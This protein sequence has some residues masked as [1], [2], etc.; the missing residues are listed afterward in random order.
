ML[1]KISLGLAILIGLATLFVAHV[2]VAPQINTLNENLTA[3]KKETT[4][5]RDDATKSKKEAKDTKTL[6]EA[7]NKQLG[8]ATNALASAVI[9]A[10]EQKARADKAVGL[11]TGVTEERNTAQQ[12][13]NQWKAL[14]LSIEQ[15]RS[16]RDDL[17]K[18]VQERDA[19][20][21]EKKVLVK[22]NKTLQDKLD[23]VLGL[24]RP[25]PTVPVGTK[26]KVIAVDPKYNFVVL[27]IGSNQGLEPK[28]KML[29][30]RDGKLIAKVRITSVEPNRSV[31]NVMP[32][33]QQEEIMEGDQVLY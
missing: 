16:Q 26:G 2:Q 12:E 27:D 3:S 21:V 28:A 1:L 6:L 7:T 17:R 5:A 15:V 33:W 14:G 23:E 30:N 24:D 25:D 29:I 8:E 4:D 20:A 18:T 31:A 10:S 32:E 13:A 22:Q 19:F 11:L 9:T